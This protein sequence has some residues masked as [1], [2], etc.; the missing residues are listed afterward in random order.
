MPT[1]THT[2]TSTQADASV[3]LSFRGRNVRSFRDEFEL[4]M[5]ATTLSEKEVRRSVSWREGGTP[6]DVLPL[7]AIFGANA[8]G[9]TNVLRAMHD[10]RMLVLQS[11]RQ[12]P[13]AKMPHVPFRLDPACAAKPSRFE[14]EIIL[15][16]VRHEYG[17]EFDSERVLE[18]WAIRYPHGRAAVLFE[19]RGDEVEYGATART[20]SRAVGELLRE[21]ALFLS[22]AAH[23]NHPVLLPLYE[24]FSR[25]LLLA[26]AMTRAWRQ[27]YTVQ[28]LE[29]D[30][31]GQLV[32]DLLRAADLGISGAR[33]YEVDDETRERLRRVARILAG[34]E[35]AEGQSLEPL[36]EDVML[37]EHRGAA[38]AVEFGPHE[39]SLGTLVWFGLVGPVIDALARGAVFL[40][41]ELDASLHPALV[42]QLVWLFQSKETNPN[43]AQLIFNTHDVTL[44]GDTS[45]NRVLGRDQIWFTEKENVG[46]TRLFSLTDLDPRKDEA[47]GKRYLAGR[48][49]AT[50]ILSKERFRHIGELVAGS[51]R[52]P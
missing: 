17:F 4:S 44:L 45:S 36:L 30:S 37:L 24:W 20:K 40:A 19:R 21:N 29:E 11:F 26:D 50:P 39:E 7:A 1:T 12:P 27:A 33:K 6:I 32:L 16:G 42:A 38:G 46:A 14:I 10:M 28:I 18:E 25:N 35:E 43:R 9:K 51:N 3:L 48:Y 13:T 47:I 8:S 52:A 31:N 49:G 23:A 15:E 34:E 5:L 41:D 2:H 22:T